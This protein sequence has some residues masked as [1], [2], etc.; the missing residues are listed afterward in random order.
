MKTKYIVGVLIIVIFII[1]AVFSLKDSLTPYVSLEEAKK[2]GEFVQV[3]GYRVDG[4]A[5][6]DLENK[7]FLFKMT[8]DQGQEFDVTYDGVKPSN[9]EQATEVIAI[10]RYADR[11]FKADQILVKCPSK[12]QAEG[13]VK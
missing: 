5:K 2:S 1:F 7:I 4:S 9:F 11:K 12:Y 10:G 13:V 3:K 6:F 8:D